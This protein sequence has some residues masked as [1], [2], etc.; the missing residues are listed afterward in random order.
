MKA[1]ILILSLLVAGS[2]TSFAQ[3]GKKVIITTSKTDHLDANGVVTRTVDEKAVVEI[4]KSAL[5]I[6]VNDEH[7]MTGTINQTPVIGA[8]H[9]KT[10][11]QLSKPC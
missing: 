10:E 9:L 1:I 7:K 3:C 5:T 11:K 4:Y 8:Y 6:N 2:V